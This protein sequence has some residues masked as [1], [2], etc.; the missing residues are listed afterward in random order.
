MR[1]QKRRGRAVNLKLRFSDFRTITREKTILG[2][3]DV[4][5]VGTMRLR[6]TNGNAGTLTYTNNGVTVTKAI[7]RQE[8]STPV[9][10]CN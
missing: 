5:Q 4:T 8:F 3:A 9:S 10:A 1:R 2:A 7:T 6:F